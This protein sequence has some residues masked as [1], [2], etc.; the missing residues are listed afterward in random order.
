M[1]A[2]TLWDLV[3]YGRDSSY[4]A[5]LL[6]LAELEHLPDD[7]IGF[8]CQQLDGDA[9]GREVLLV[10]RLHHWSLAVLS[11]ASLGDEIEVAGR[12]L[13]IDTGLRLAPTTR[14][15]TNPARL[16]VWRR[17]AA[18]PETQQPITGSLAA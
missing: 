4:T 11:S 13:E 17:I 16:E 5:T 14:V 6:V 3:K 9:P 15:V 10:A 2:P 1:S 8:V 18:G 12:A 7:G